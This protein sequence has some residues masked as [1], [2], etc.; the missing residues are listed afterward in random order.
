MVIHLI[1]ERD[2][3]VDQILETIIFFQLSAEF[4]SQPIQVFL[5]IVDIPM[6]SQQEYDVNACERGS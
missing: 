2:P 3:W 4:V 5:G 6:L 1:R